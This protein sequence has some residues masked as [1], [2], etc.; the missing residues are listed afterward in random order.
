MYLTLHYMY[1]CYSCAA[2]Y[3]MLLMNYSLGVTGFTTSRY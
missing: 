2:N 3:V 1:N